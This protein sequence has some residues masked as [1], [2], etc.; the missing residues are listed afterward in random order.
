MPRALGRRQREVIE[1]VF[2]D[3]YIGCA[4]SKDKYIEIL[5]AAAHPG[6][7]LTDKHPTG[8]WGHPCGNP[9]RDGGAHVLYDGEPPPLDDALEH[10]LVSY[11]YDSSTVYTHQSV[12]IR[13]TPTRDRIGRGNATAR[14]LSAAISAAGK[15]GGA[16]PDP[17]NLISALAVAQ[18]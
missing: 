18:C 15:K 10:S 14:C 12:Y 11:M 7:N 3:L 9:A 6:I 5:E 17:Y 16:L 4:S 8:L 1:S 2:M 13:A